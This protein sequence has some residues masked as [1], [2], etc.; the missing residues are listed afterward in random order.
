[1]LPFECGLLHEYQPRKL[2]PVDCQIF[3]AAPTHNKPSKCVPKAKPSPE[4][5]REIG[6]KNFPGRM[7]GKTAEFMG[8]LYD[9]QPQIL[10]ILRRIIQPVLAPDLPL[11]STL[12][13][14]SF[15]H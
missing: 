3:T 11:K 9:R 6:V 4:T 12:K 14:P 1:M 8:W 13:V 2:S 7:S 10:K 5:K 15:G